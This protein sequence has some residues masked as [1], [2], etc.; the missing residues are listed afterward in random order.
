MT[1]LFVA[2]VCFGW[3][4]GFVVMGR[5]EYRRVY[6]E[7]LAAWNRMYGTPVPGRAH[8]DAVGKAYEMIYKWPFE[9]VFGIITWLLTSEHLL[10]VPDSET[11]PWLQ[12]STDALIKRLDRELGTETISPEIDPCPCGYRTE[13]PIH[14]GAGECHTDDP[15]KCNRPKWQDPGPEIIVTRDPG[16]I[17]QITYPEAEF[18]MP[19]P[20]VRYDR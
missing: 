16:K 12:D 9:M 17:V 19:K 8:K 20:G 6:A 15:G 14:C 3:L 18:I 10:G 7:S 13:C 2:M 11:D 1:G 5:R 4:T